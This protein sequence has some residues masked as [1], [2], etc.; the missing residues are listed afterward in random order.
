M[1]LGLKLWSINKGYIKPA[2]ELIEKGYFQYIELFAVMN[3]F[4]DTI[5]A[6]QSI[7]IPYIIHAPHSSGGINWA[8]PKLRDNNEKII[9]ESYLFA[10]ALKAHSII[11][12]PGI[13]GP[14][15]ESLTQLTKL[16]DSRLCIENK[17]LALRVPVAAVGST[18]EEIAL[19]IDKTGFRFCLD[20]GH[21]LCS[22]NSHNV[23]PLN[24]LQN[25]QALN[26]AM[27][28]LSDGDIHGV[29]DLHQHLGHGSYPLL[30]ILSTL[31]TN[32]PISIET[33]KDYEDRLDDVIAD[34]TL[35]RQLLE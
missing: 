24:Y 22:A 12:H 11:I 17:P 4:K 16:N 23:D 20:I 33:N 9:Q 31:N 29:R 30:Q 15:E 26:P 13:G 25:F 1:L 34:V 35:V 7:N 8:D 6:W 19:I 27:Y 14:I 5:H 3:S 28:H 2:Q 32:L 10:D 21:A 18:P